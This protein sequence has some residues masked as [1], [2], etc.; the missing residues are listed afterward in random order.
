MNLMQ[1]GAKTDE[2]SWNVY[3]SC[4]KYGIFLFII[5]NIIKKLVITYK[6]IKI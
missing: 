1:V 4:R 3:E 2:V 5:Y 6:N